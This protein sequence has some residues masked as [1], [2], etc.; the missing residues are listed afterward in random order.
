MADVSGWLEAA[1]AHHDVVEWA[2]P[3]GADWARAWSECPRGDWLLGI[4]ARAGAD[5]RAVVAGACACAR[6]ALEYVPEHEARPAAAIAAA[7]RWLAGEG[8]PAE[9]ARLAIEAEEAV[10][11]APDPAVASAAMAALAALRSVQAPEEAA[12]SAASAVQAALLDAG[13]C[14]VMAAMRHA[15]VACAD[16]VREHVPRPAL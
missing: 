4:A 5:P 12:H 15:Q 3:Y 16:L 13:D 11:R 1:G 8:D 2:R 10:D 7:E 14:A 9:R 6:F